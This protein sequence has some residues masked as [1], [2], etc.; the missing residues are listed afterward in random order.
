MFCYIY[1]NLNALL[2]FVFHQKSLSHPSENYGKIP[3]KCH[4]ST[5]FIYHILRVV[6]C[7][8]IG[9]YIA[10]FL[11]MNINNIKKEIIIFNILANK[12][13]TAITNILTQYY[14][15]KIIF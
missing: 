10:S 5:H 3:S 4:L 8:A 1:I 2:Y 6:L 12:T 11:V 14:R 13:I 7:V 15:V 9:K